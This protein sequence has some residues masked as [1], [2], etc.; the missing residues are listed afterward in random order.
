MSGKDGIKVIDCIGCGNFKIVWQ[1]GV[2]VRCPRCKKM[3][4]FPKKITETCARCG[5]T[6]ETTESDLDELFPD[7]DIPPKCMDCQI[8]EDQEAELAYGLRANFEPGT[9]VVDISTGQ[10]YTVPH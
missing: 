2:E 4:K 1:D 7:W 10:E 9:K 5:K 6:Y 8:K 3:H